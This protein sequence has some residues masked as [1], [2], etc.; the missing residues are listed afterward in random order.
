M[1]YLRFSNFTTYRVIGD[2]NDIAFRKL[3]GIEV[4]LWEI[5]RNLKPVETVKAVR[6]RFWQVEYIIQTITAGCHQTFIR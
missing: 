5:T 1:K 2:M 6:L 4:V 3:A